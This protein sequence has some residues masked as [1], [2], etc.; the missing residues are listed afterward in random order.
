MGNEAEEVPWVTRLRKATGGHEESTLAVAEGLVIEMPDLVNRLR[1][2]LASGSCKEVQRYSHTLKS[3]MRYLTDGPELAIAAKIEA[4][5]KSEQLDQVSEL[6]AEISK[7]V[8]SWIEQIQ[9][10]LDHRSR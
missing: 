3:S 8:E 6:I 5:G 9:Q 7:Y 2:A 10:W 4:A 1:Q